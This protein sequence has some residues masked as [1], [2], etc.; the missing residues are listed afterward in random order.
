[1]WLWQQLENDQRTNRQFSWQDMEQSAC[2]Y[3]SETAKCTNLDERP[4]EHSQGEPK[5]CEP[6]PQ[7][8]TTWR[9]GVA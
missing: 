8:K 4:A 7:P 9:E 2:K 5:L 1:V 6:W 3:D